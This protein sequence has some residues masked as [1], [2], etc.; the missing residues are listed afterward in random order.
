MERER[1]ATI[2]KNRV[3]ELVNVI[4]DSPTK[5]SLEMYRVYLLSLG[6]T[7]EDHF[8]TVQQAAEPEQLQCELSIDSY[9]HSDFRN[10]STSSPYTPVML[11]LSLEAIRW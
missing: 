1:L 10:R 4:E 6:K 7:V 3:Q 5:Y 2:I 11:L 8:D 9:I